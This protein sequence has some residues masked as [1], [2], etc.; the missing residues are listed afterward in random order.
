MISDVG[1][2][3]HLVDFMEK[4]NHQLWISKGLGIMASQE[5][6]GGGGGVQFP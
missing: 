6:V 3:L 5:M 1:D 4:Y 2:E